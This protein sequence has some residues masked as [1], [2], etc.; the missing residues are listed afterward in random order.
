MREQ[1]IAALTE[2]WSLDEATA[3]KLA[4]KTFTEM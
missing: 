1:F 3:E 4:N 2:A